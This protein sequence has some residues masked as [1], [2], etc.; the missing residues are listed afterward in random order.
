MANS[1]NKKLFFCHVNYHLDCHAS[2]TL[3]I[4][5]IIIIKPDK[6]HNFTRLLH[7]WVWY[8]PSVCLDFEFVNCK[9]INK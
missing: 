1:Q 5:I 3:K 2:I 4:I 7:K 8:Y 6:S 9:E